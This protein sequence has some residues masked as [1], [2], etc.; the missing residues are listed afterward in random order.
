MKDHDVRSDGSNV[1]A[2]EV[3]KSWSTPQS[4][5]DG[6]GSIHRPGCDAANLD[7][8]EAKF[9]VVLP[10][11]F[12]A[13]YKLSDGTASH[14][15]HL[16]TFYPVAVI[17]HYTETDASGGCWV[18]FADYASS[19]SLFLLRFAVGLPVEVLADPGSTTQALAERAVPVADSFDAF[20]RTYLRDPAQLTAHAHR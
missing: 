15:P 5:R 16:L 18:G 7:A 2:R 3:A 10:Q 13:L 8:F 6:T 9:E 1:L 11:T 17:A 14:D 20:L 4:P 12:R 19:R